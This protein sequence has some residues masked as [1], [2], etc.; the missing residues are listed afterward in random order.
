MHH[1]IKA[2]FTLAAMCGEHA[3]AE[4]AEKFDVYPKQITQWK[5]QA[6]ES[7]A[8]AFDKDATG[9]IAEA[10]RK[11]MSERECKLSLTRQCHLLELPRSTVYHRPRPAGTNS[12]TLIRR[13]VELHLAWPWMSA[14]SIRHQLVRAGYPVCRDRVRRLMR[15]MGIHDVYRRQRTP[16]YKLYPHLLKDMVIERP[17][18]LW[19]TDITYLPVPRGFLYLVAIM[20]L[21]S[22]Q[23]R[24]RRLPNTLTADCC[25]EALDEALQRSG[26]PEIFDTEQGT[27]LTGAYFICRLKVKKILVSMDGKGR[28]LDNVFIERL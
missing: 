10:E 7:M 26:T 5:L 25:V 14:R 12:L 8:S 23:V 18:Q 3:L 24:E 17:N 16:E 2:K 9:Q 13:I 4:L 19:A 11:T 1:C 21:Y 15:K 22:C 6:M 27:Q 28:W 20:E